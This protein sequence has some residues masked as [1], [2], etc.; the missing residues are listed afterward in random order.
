MKKIRYIL[1]VLLMISACMFAAILPVSAGSA[2]KAVGEV[3]YHQDFAVLSD[4]SKSGIVS[5]TLSSPNASFLCIG[6]SLEINIYDNNRVYAILPQTEAENSYTVEFD[7]SFTA[8][9]TENGYL[10]FL[11]TCRGPEPTNLTYLTIRANGTIDNFEKPDEALSKS[12]VDGEEI[13]VKIPI[14]NGALHRIELMSERGACTLDRDNVLVI[15]EGEMGFAVRNASVQISEIYI[16]NGT[17]YAEK[18][19]Y[20]ATQSYAADESP[21]VIPTESSPVLEHSPAT[22]DPVLTVL[23]AGVCICICGALFGAALLKIYARNHTL[24]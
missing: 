22:S 10:A 3:L 15:N 1:M 4:F 5:G 21:L 19:G 17:D 12:I 13:H 8:V 9:N 24:F 7:F 16:V 18:T 11:L 23:L 6:D 14:E 2:E 20:Y